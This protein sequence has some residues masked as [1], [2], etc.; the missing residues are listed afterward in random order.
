M[1]QS[2][3]TVESVAE[4]LKRFFEE[5]HPTWNIH[6]IVD[7]VDL[8]TGWETEL[9]RF[10]IHYDEKGFSI[11]R[12]FVARLYPG[13]RAARKAKHEYM[14][15]KRLGRTEYPVPKVHELV[16]ETNVLG[17][18]FI[19]MDWLDGHNMMDDFLGTPMEEL[20]PHIEAFSN[21]FVDLHRVDPI[22][23]FPEA[24]C[25]ED[26]Q[27]YLDLVIKKTKKDLNK[28]GPSWLWPV[29][30]WLEE[31][32]QGV[33]AGRFSVL[34]RDFHP[35]NI[36]VRPDGSHS[37][38]DWAAASFG[39]FREDLMWTVLLAGAFWGRFFGVAML[40][41]Y[42][43]A[44]GEVVKDVDFFEVAAIYRRIQDTSI[45]FL[46]GAEEAGMRAD[47]I[48]Q[49]KEGLGHLHNV[50]ALLEERTGFRLPEFDD[51]LRTVDG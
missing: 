37:I 48:E 16:T 33:S 44:S 23:V 30:N 42:E 6:K 32:S 21:L 39:D 43:T 26:F 14:V 2:K 13:R 10:N 50:H 45:S 18:P 20:G 41:A 46:R 22:L 3:R 49:M 7:V 34:H 35:G 19:I 4:P 38:I 29:L 27:G 17:V 5:K 24:G 47:A 9:Y 11:S 25:F 28:R 31:Q 51:L 12:R 8:T 36:L 15:M 1:V 40:E